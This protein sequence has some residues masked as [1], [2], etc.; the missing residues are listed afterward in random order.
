M[1]AKRTRMIAPK[2]PPTMAPVLFLEPELW[3]E[4]GAEVI[5]LD[6]VGREDDVVESE[7]DPLDDDGVVDGS[8]CVRMNASTFRSI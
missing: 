4:S 6:P 2:T 3:L 5:V 7:L 1:I 8:G